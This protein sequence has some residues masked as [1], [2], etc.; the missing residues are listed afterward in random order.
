MST[1]SPQQRLVLEATQ[2]LE[3]E[4]YLFGGGQSAAVNCYIWNKSPDWKKD[5]ISQCRKRLIIE[6]LFVKTN[7]RIELTEAG[8]RAL[9]TGNTNSNGN[10]KGHQPQVP[11]D[12][13]DSLTRRQL[14]ELAWICSRSAGWI[15]L[16]ILKA[17]W[18]ISRGLCTNAVALQPERF[19]IREG[20]LFLLTHKAPENKNPEEMSPEEYGRWLCKIDPSLAI[21]RGR[22]GYRKDGGRL[23]GCGI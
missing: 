3:K 5:A 10:G 11:T 22:R 16:D 8:R 14:D 12:S 23:S 17:D 2:H 1:L 9:A 13:F 6:G 20:R 4:S 21:R 15:S 19:A 18:G 7:N